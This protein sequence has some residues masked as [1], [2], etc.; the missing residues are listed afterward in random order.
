M[1]AVDA[2][3]T[4][5]PTVISVRPSRGPSARRRG[6]HNDTLMWWL[7]F[8]LA[9]VPLPL[10]SNRPLFWAL[11]ALVVGAIGLVYV[12]TIWRSA[13][14]I[15]LPLRLVAVPAVL[16]VVL[17]LYL[18]VQALPLG[19]VP[20]LVLPAD[21]TVLIPH[22][23]IS[24]M[25][26][27]TWLMLLRQVSYAVFALLILQVATLESRR[28]RVFSALLIIICAYALWGLASLRL[29]DTI[30]GLPKW[31][32]QGSATSTFV[33]RNSFAT[34]LAF[35]VCLA[36]ASFAQAILPSL[37][38]GEATSRAPLGTITLHV[39]AMILLFAAVL[40]TQSRMG[41]FVSV[42]GAV[43]VAGAALLRGRAGWPAAMAAVAL[44]IGAACAG[45]YLFG[46]GLFE[47]VGSLEQS[48]VV[49]TDF[50]QQILG[51]IGLRPLT[52]FGGGAFEQAYALVHQ[53][54]VNPDVV[55]DR[56]HNTYLTLWSE[57]G[58]VFGSLP[59]L[60][61]ALIFGQ[62]LLALVLRRG[63][64]LPQAVAL[65]VMLV[66]GLHSLVDFSLEIQANTYF[67]VALVSIGLGSTLFASRPKQ[68]E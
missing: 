48:A 37:R 16:Q 21:P 2:E 54:P 57:L 10:A 65:S 62:I 43:S 27:E 63:D 44:A 40:A 51:L 61:Y 22:P 19:F 31:A 53:L 41:L 33:N 23:S 45:L 67:F 34:F 13:S 25:A 20:P 35:G 11:S 24:I 59:I 7:L 50:Y 4:P 49:R 8:V 60:I 14:P 36:S 39:V 26:G 55:W 6:G 47:R 17:C 18:I 46:D 56:G 32:Y 38:P 42:V 12:L 68:S 3:P 58:I 28:T 30:L 29:G 5:P 9:L 66:G 52:G 15:R 64:W 1:S